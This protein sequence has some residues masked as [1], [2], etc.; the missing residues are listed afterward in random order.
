VKKPEIKTFEDRT[1]ELNAIRIAL[2]FIGIILVIFG[3]LLASGP[4]PEIRTSSSIISGI[5][6]IA[7]FL[8][9]RAFIQEKFS[10]SILKRLSRISD[11]FG[12]RPFQI[13][14]ILAAPLV[15]LIAWLAAGDGL[16]M[17]QPNLA[18][19]AWVAAIGFFLVGHRKGRSTPTPTPWS[20][21]DMFALWLLFIGALMLRGFLLEDIP[22]LLTGDEASAG[23]TAVEFIQGERNNIFVTGWFSFPSLFFWTQS[24]SIKLLGQTTLG[25]RFPSMLAGALTI[26]ALYWF[27][28]PFFGRKMAFGSSIFLAVFH[29][30]I[31]FSRIGLNNIWDGLFFVLFIGIVWRAW[32]EVEN[33]P[34]KTSPSF[35]LAG[36]ALGL[37]QYFYTSAR[38][39][40]GIFILFVVLLYI[41]NRQAVRRRLPGL[42]STLLGFI[43]IVLPLAAYYTTHPEQFTAPFARVSHLGPW[44]A[45]EIALTGQSAIS[46]IATQFKQATLGFTHVN[47][48]NWYTPDEPMLLAIPSALF[49]LGAIILV[50][51]LRQPL[52]Q[53]LLLWLLTSITI[54][55][56]SE[57]TPAAQRLTFVAPAV[58]ILVVLPLDSVLDW[59][60]PIMPQRKNLVL[61][62]V[63]AILAISMIGDISF[64]F[65]SYSMSQKFGDINTEVAQRVAQ[66]LNTLEGSPTVYFYGLPRMGYYTHS[67]IQY[68]APHATGEDIPDPLQEAPGDL[69]KG[70][71][72]FVFLPERIEEIEFVRA[73]FPD[74]EDL[75]FVGRN[76]MQL[77]TIYLIQNRSK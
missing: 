49:I 10:P 1:I 46:I 68:L 8:S 40:A 9:A 11:W 42:T 4:F 44:L 16:I 38:I 36:L 76:N 28:R 3:Q 12:L 14:F 72:V 25:L 56:L 34:P 61:L 31:H 39:L 22:W 18:V 67:S 57:S 19:L 33:S 75:D 17:F 23:L 54:S 27:T 45:D 71:V 65:G 24:L 29:F 55:A 73:A 20:R 15:S 48:R 41:Q 62:G 26:P 69:A 7:F 66:Y 64:Y 6:I 58:A 63:S 74:G 50:F 13:L 53:W 2:L 70:M 5:G 77:F 51:K 37:S 35:A 47:I 32:N 60:T 30:H 21:E 52:F 43:V 59:L